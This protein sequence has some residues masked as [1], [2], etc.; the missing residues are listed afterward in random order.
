MSTAEKEIKVE[1]SAPPKEAAAQVRRGG[2][3]GKYKNLLVPP[4]TTQRPKFEGKSD[5]LK[6][7]I[8][9]CSDG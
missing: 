7:F 6:G 8:Y 1:E 5:S 3:R 9:D 4:T 2:Y